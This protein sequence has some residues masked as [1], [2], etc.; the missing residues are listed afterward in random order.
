MLNSCGLALSQGEGSDFHP[1]CNW[2]A[3][4][5]PW[6]QSLCKSLEMIGSTPQGHTCPDNYGSSEK[7]EKYGNA[8]KCS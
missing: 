8:G 2:E 3:T 4:N 7:L 5:S 6:L 1:G